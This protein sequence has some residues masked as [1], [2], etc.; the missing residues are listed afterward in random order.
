MTS[1]KIIDNEKQ[2]DFEFCQDLSD[3]SFRDSGPALH[4]FFSLLLGSLVL[5]QFIR[6]V[7]HFAGV[8]DLLCRSENTKKPDREGLDLGS[9]RLRLG[10]FP[11]STLTTW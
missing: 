2:C 3:G 7:I 9:G 4:D 6:R 5:F 10:Y 8:R 11:I 1:A